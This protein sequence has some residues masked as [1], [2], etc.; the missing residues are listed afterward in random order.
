[1]MKKK[2]IV[3][4]ILAAALFNGCTP[5]RSVP[6]FE[7]AEISWALFCEARGYDPAADAPRQYNE[8]LDGWCGS[9]EEEQALI[10]AG[11]RPY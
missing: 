9:I 7:L 3:I 8:Y 4:I 11:I 6:D 1:M 2:L 5:L 10:D